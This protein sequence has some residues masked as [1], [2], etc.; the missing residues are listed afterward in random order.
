[1]FQQ[2]W[3]KRAGKILEGADPRTAQRKNT[4]WMEIKTQPQPPGDEPLPRLRRRRDLP[5]ARRSRRRWGLGLGRRQAE[6]LRR[7]RLFGK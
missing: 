5:I 6:E 4:G 2:H 7:Q 3:P 1:L